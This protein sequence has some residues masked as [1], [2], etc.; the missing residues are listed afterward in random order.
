MSTSTAQHHGYMEHE[1][2]PTGTRFTFKPSGSEYAGMGGT[3]LRSCFGCGRHKAA[4]KGFF[5]TLAGKPQFLCSDA[6]ET[7]LGLKPR[8]PALPS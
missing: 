8:S 2:D 1:V 3:Y 4:S 5:R 6:C 7:G